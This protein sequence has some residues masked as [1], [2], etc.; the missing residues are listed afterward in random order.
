MRTIKLYNDHYADDNPFSEAGQSAPIKMMFGVLNPETKVVEAQHYL[1]RCKDYLNDALYQTHV[2]KSMGEVYDFDWD[3][4]TKLIQEDACRLI[5]S[6]PQQCREDYIPFAGLR[7][8]HSMEDKFNMI[9]TEVEAAEIAGN[10]D[11]GVQYW[12]VHGDAGW[13]SSLPLLSLYT[14]L[15]RV[16]G[17]AK[18]EDTYISNLITRI[19]NADNL[20]DY[21]IAK[22]LARDNFRHLVTLLKY[23]YEIFDDVNENFEGFVP[24]EEVKTVSIKLIHSCTG[25]NSLMYNCVNKPQEFGRLWSN[26][27]LEIQKREQENFEGKLLSNN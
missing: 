12:V 8:L 11:N 24:G 2:N 10:V 18:P 13:Q 23:R 20:T 17:W 26:R 9:R 5:I 14:Y 3:P 6:C 15:L 19:S 22:A 21:V 27:I 4:S 25:I 16:I 1:A 7:L